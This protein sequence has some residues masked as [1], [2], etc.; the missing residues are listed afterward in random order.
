MVQDVDTLL[1]LTMGSPVHC[2]DG[3]GGHVHRVVLAPAEEEVRALV[4]ERGLVHHAVVVPIGYVARA[5]GEQVTLAI[6]THELAALPRYAEVD[7]VEP[8]PAWAAQ[9]GYAASSAR[10]EVSATAPFN[11]LYGQRPAS[12]LIRQHLHGGLSDQ[13]VPIGRRT[14]VSCPAGLV[15]HVDRVLLEP[16]SHRFRALVARLGHVHDKLVQVP[17]DWVAWLAEDEI[18]LNRDRS[19]VKHLPEYSLVDPL[20]QGS[21]YWHGEAGG[22]WPKGGGSRQSQ[23]Q[24]TAQKS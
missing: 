24:E 2:Q 14:K 9:H 20:T 18:H 11:T 6:G 17:A 7:Y 22:H 8:D 10:Y 15:G 3:H 5:D 12:A 4:V 13:E 19:E 21:S 16:V 23:F 1:T